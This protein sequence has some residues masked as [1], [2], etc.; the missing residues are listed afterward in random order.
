VLLK[1]TAWT[2]DRSMAGVLVAETMADAAPLEVKM[3]LVPT[4]SITVRV[5]STDGKAI[6]NAKLVVS[7][8]ERRMDNLH[9]RPV[10]G[11]GDGRYRVTGLVASDEYFVHAV[12]PGYRTRPENHKQFKLESG[13]ARDVGTLVLQPW[14]KAD[15][16]E[17]MQKLLSGSMGQYMVD[18]G[19]QGL[20]ALGP[21][22]RS[23]EPEILRLLL[24]VNPE[25][26]FFRRTTIHILASIGGPS[27]IPALETCLTDT[28]D[29]V[30]QAAAEALAKI[31][32]A[33]PA[34]STDAT[35]AA[36]ATAKST[37]GDK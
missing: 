30:R 6:D 16:P 29:E 10:V 35:S 33:N 17:L 12:A 36:P 3:V 11:L 8:D 4:A 27:A 24:S 21:E 9:N 2:P 25:S 34:A 14:T 28:D 7:D 15:T 31:R 13:E 20:I 23:A 18:E 5:E 37:P 1:F 32:A 26:R 19:E 22:A